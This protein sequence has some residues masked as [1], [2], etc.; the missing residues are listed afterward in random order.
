MLSENDVNLTGTLPDVTTR[1][2]GLV[3][4]VRPVFRLY[5]GLIADRERWALWLPVGLGAGIAVYFSLP[6]EPPGWVGA[7]AVAAALVLGVFGAGCRDVRGALAIIMAMAVGSVALGFAAAQLRTALVAA[8]VLDSRLGPVKVE[9]RIDLIEDRADG[10]RATLSE[11]YIDRLVAEQT[12]FRV[13][14]RLRGEQPSLVPGQRIVVRAVLMPPPA[15]SA[16][17]AFDFQRSSFFDRLGAVGYALGPAEVSDADPG[18]SSWASAVNR[19]RQAIDLRIRARLPGETGAVAT[20]LMT[21]DRGAIPPD[22]MAAIRDSGLAHLLAISG[23]HIGLVAGVLFFSVRGALALIGPVAVRAPTKKWAAVVGI[24][25]AGAYAILSGGNVPS[26]RAF[27]MISVVFLAVLVDRRGLSMRSVAWAAVLI[28]LAAPESLLSASFQMSFAAVTALIAAY[29]TVRLPDAR[30]ADPPALPA[31]VLL[32]FAGVAL[33]TLIAGMATAPF[34]IHHFNRYA[35]YGLAANLLAVPVTALWVMP[36][37]VVAFCLMPFGLEALALA[38]VGWGVDVVIAAARMV[39]GWPGAVITLPATSP[40]GFAMVV[41]GGL[42]LCLWRHRWRY[43]GALG[44]AAGMFVLLGAKPP[45]VLVDGEAKLFAVRGGDG[46]LV[47]SSRRAAQFARETWARRNGEDLNDPEALPLWPANGADDDGRLACD[48]LGCILRSDG[49]TIALIHSAEALA[50]DCHAADVI[51]AT[52]P[53]RR[54]CPAA[55]VIVDRFDLWRHG[56]H[57][58]WLRPDHVR[59]E[60]VAEHRGDRPWV[61]GRRSRAERAAARAKERARDGTDETDGTD[62]ADRT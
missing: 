25:G 45:D 42:W 3:G 1:V 5:E 51:V 28:L 50:E 4:A 62:D 7:A 52:V 15:P 17:G 48:G 23:L 39:A 32:Y 2:A 49:H 33:T 36:W 16:P 46:S 18:G 26:Q 27:L 11:L 19:L 9:G 60:S 44:V 8:P 59:V 37:A 6:T 41:V 57:A 14:V 35:E 24:V 56:A 38:P 12:P 47:V 29:E 55:R 54:P 43:L 34:A 22:V 58:L 21:G 53:V 40:A 20:A 61:V 31:R 13:R 10:L 30:G